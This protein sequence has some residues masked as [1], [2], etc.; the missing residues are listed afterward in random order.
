MALH[1]YEG[2]I[3]TMTIKQKH[4]TFEIQIRQGN[5]LAVFIHV[6]KDEESDGYIHTLYSFFADE[7]HLK[8]CMKTMGNPFGDE[9]VSIRLNMKYKESPKLL[10]H[11]VK[12]CNVECYYED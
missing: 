5:C 2:L 11:L 4:G 8:K 10:K 1:Y 12:L 9:I 6:R 7:A 3:G